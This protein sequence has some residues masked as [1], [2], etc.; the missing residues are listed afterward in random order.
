MLV[1]PGEDVAD[2]CASY[3]SGYCLSFDFDSATVLLEAWAKDSADDPEPHVRSGDVWYSQN[4]WKEAIPCYR[5][6]IAIDP[7]HVRAQLSLAQCL[8]RINEPA[9]AES[10]FRSV[11]RENPASVEARE[12]LGTCLMSLSRLEEARTA[13]LA[14]VERNP[15]HLEARRRLGE[16]E[17]ALERPE[18]AIDWLKPL[19]DA[20]PQDK[21]YCSLYAQ[22]LQELGRVDEARRWWEAVREAE[23]ALA[24]LEKLNESVKND[25]TNPE[26]RYEIGSLLL[27]FRSRDDGAGWFK[28]LLQ[29]DPTH[30]GAHEAL[31]EYYEKTGQAELSRQHRQLARDFD[32]GNHDS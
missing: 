27:R 11:I 24:K 10:A 30:A 6:A 8:L 14:V 25:P 5:R 13:L 15:G 32:G 18:R 7:R 1:N 31:A 29:F 2:I 19:V 16:L 23:A 28:S 3:V 21:A 4:E 22:A 17:L 20:W 9:A 26:L 12:G